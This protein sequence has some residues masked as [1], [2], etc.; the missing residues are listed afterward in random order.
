MVN[1]NANIIGGAQFTS[2]S[3]SF[4][5]PPATASLEV[6]FNGSDPRSINPDGPFTPI[7]T[8][9]TSGTLG[10]VA[11]QSTVQSCVW[12]PGLSAFVCDNAS[13]FY[14]DPLNR[15][16]ATQFAQGAGGDIN[17][18]GTAKLRYNSLA[19][20]SFSSGFTSVVSFIY[21]P[22]VGSLDFNYGTIIGG[23]N[24]SV[25]ITNNPGL[26]VGI[27]SVTQDIIS[28]SAYL[29]G[30]IDWVAGDYIMAAV[31]YNTGSQVWNAYYLKGDQIITS[32]MTGSV[33]ERTQSVSFPFNATNMSAVFNTANSFESCLLYDKTLTPQEILSAFGYLRR[34]TAY[35]APNKDLICLFDPSNPNSIT[36]GNSG[37][38]NSLSDYEVN[39]NQ[40]GSGP[41][42]FNGSEGW[43]EFN[44][45]GSY[46]FNNYT[47][48][49]STSSI[50]SANYALRNTIS[51]SYTV[52]QLF[53]ASSDGNYN[54]LLSF[55]ANRVRP[56]YS[57]GGLI[58][59]DITWNSTNKIYTTGSTSKSIGSSYIVTDYN[60]A[61]ITSSILETPAIY[62]SDKWY[63]VTTVLDNTTFSASL[64][65]NDNLVVSASNVNYNNV[66]YTKPGFPANGGNTNKLA[67]N[68]SGSIGPT[69]IY[70]RALSSTE[71]ENIYDGYSSKWNLD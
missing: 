57:G 58:P 36:T 65:V 45:T 34:T 2:G 55:N 7:T 71:I 5:N 61:V 22:A 3:L 24:I 12:N 19:T 15:Q 48:W 26:E 50:I 70:N 23:T 8:N 67:A 6:W 42:F 38:Y 9:I 21:D 40:G 10:S 20:A 32:D 64:Y 18:D 66:N 28:G 17:T 47:N 43:I 13:Y 59:A 41:G 62:E 53:N 27:N 46:D 14:W 11:D 49:P 60:D 30:E 29:T 33:F 68:F 39:L 51:D 63:M 16:L 54:E 52:V 56:S 4:T 25:K 1:V 69:I 31:T 35:Y 44:R 37:S